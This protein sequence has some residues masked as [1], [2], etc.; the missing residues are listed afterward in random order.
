MVFKLQRPILV[1]GLGLTAAGWAVDSLYSNTLHLGS[2][3]VWG[4]IAI[5]SGCWWLSQRSR[6]LALQGAAPTV[7]RS[8]T[9]AMFASVEA[10]IAQLEAEL[11][12]AANQSAEQSANQ[13]A[14]QS[15]I[16][17]WRSQLAQLPSE[18][19][20]SQIRLAA[21]GGKA[22]G[23][24]ALTQQ[25]VTQLSGTAAL[26][27]TPDS[28]TPDS[29]TLDTATPNTLT[30]LAPSETDGQRSDLVVFVTAGDLTDSE[31]QTV[32]QLLARNQRVVLAFNKQDQYSAA[33]RPVIL[34]QIRDRLKDA[35]PLD[36]VVAIA[37]HPAP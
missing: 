5:G 4:A 34:Q 24:T 35:L 17:R 14:N 20:R 9:E 26:P 23:K 2:S 3:M 6:P 36:D 10:L 29:A 16:A 31:F 12:A 13:S 1:G 33:D 18:L 22:V 11:D 7:D 27:A 8:T 21:M 32:Q 28:A 15:A 30:P 25:L 37:T 19:D